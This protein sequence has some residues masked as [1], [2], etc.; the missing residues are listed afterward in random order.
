MK[1]YA[2]IKVVNGNCFIHAEN[3]DTIEAA[4]TNFHGLCQ[5]L[6]NAPDVTDAA[7]IIVDEKLN[8]VEGYKEIIH[9]NN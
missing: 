8:I 5:T 1:K 9:H 4:K 3:I 2:I 6:W 7:V